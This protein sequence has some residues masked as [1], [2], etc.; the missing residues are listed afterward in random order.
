M[1]E[2]VLAPPPHAPAKEYETSFRQILAYLGPHKWP[3]IWTLVLSVLQ[4]LTLLLL[5]VLASVAI[6]QMAEKNFPAMVITFIWLLLSL[7]AQ[8]V[9]TWQKMWTNQRIGNEIIRTMRNDLMLKMQEQNYT[10]LDGH[11]TGDL[12]SRTTSDVNLLKTFMAQQIAYFTREILMVFLVF[13]VMFWFNV[14]LGLFLLP[15]LGGLFV[16]M[17]FYRRKMGPLFFSSRQTFGRLTTVLQE[18]ITGI[19][20][21]RSFG[22]KKEEI[23]KFDRES[24]TYFRQSVKLVKYQSLF[25]PTIRGINQ[26]AMIIVIFI[27]GALAL[28]PSSGFTFGKLFGF[29]ILMNFVT[30][31][32]RF[33]TQF[34]GD[35]SKI[36]GACDRVTEVLNANS[37][38]PEAPDATEIP[39]I[40]GVVEF[41][42]VWF[43]FKKDQHYELKDVNFK[44]EPGEIIAIL[45]ATGSGKT[46]LVNLIPR[47]YEVDKG[48]ILIDGQDIR[49][50]TQ[51]SLRRQVAVVAQESFLFSE[52][53]RNNIA[54]HDLDRAGDDDWLRRCANLAQIDDWI[55]SLEQGYDTVVGERGVTVSGGQRQR[56][57]IARAL[58]SRPHVL[59]LD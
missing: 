12:M 45:G 15:F 34:L 5:P 56:L 42:H 11:P 41:R 8:A 39:P 57:C 40:Q 19:R 52:S 23:R 17:F 43:S 2:K 32:V 35:M 21:V 18:N 14:T 54:F 30:E 22:R 33:I 13:A 26:V 46:A 24:D 48:A 37:I 16:V 59:I 9:V 50:V 6:D 28:N 29:V 20:V 44:T 3:F 51:K 25:D 10:W 55:M 31:P 47:L 49:S 1:T 27:G 4:D 7:I 58:F 53:I 38:I 36:N